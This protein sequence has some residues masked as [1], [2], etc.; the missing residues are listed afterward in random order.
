MREDGHGLPLR[1][2]Y[3][4]AAGGRQACGGPGGG[5]IDGVGP[6]G[7]APASTELKK[8]SPCAGRPDD[9]RADDDREPSTD[10]IIVY[11]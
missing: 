6:H 11:P 2:C 10:N 1:H 5:A 8:Q 7:G 3:P 4:L 9:P